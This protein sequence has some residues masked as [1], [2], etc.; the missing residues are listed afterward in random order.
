MQITQP[1]APYYGRLPHRRAPGS[2]YHSRFSVLSAVGKLS[3]DWMFEILEH[4]ILLHHKKTCLIHAY[5]L[6]PNHP[7][8]ILDDWAAWC[9]FRLFYRL[10]I[11]TGQ[12]KGR[13]S[14]LI[15]LR[16]GRSG[17]LWMKE[18]YDRIIRDERDLENV[19]K[20]IHDNP[21]RWRLVDSAE[22]YRW[23]SVSTIY[24]GRQEYGGWFDLSHAADA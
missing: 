19:I 18:S 7:L 24:S 5:I 3:Q 22:Q 11:I 16:R 2:I 10:E 20:Y 23:S 8:P 21:V 4:A 14:R 1:G 15:N 6:M 17:P 13:S 12:I 9:D